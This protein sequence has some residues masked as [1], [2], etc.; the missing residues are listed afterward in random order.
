MNISKKENLS[1]TSNELKK[2]K[3]KKDYK[4]CKNCMYQIASLRTCKWAEN[5][6]DGKLHLIC[7]RWVHN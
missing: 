5:G 3:R 1:I 4:G 2:I 6:G 7:P